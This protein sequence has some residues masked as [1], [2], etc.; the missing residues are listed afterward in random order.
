M[1]KCA[2]HRRRI[3]VTFCDKCGDAMCETCV[4]TTHYLQDLRGTLCIPCYIKNYKTMI[5]EIKSSQKKF[6][7][8][9]FFGLLF[10]G[11]GLAL[12]FTESYKNL[13]AVKIVAH[14]FMALY[15]WLFL[16]LTGPKRNMK[17]EEFP[18]YF[19]DMGFEK[20]KRR[21]LFL[22]ILYSIL[23]F[24][25][26]IVYSP[27]NFVIRLFLKVKRKAQQEDVPSSKD[28]IKTFKRQIRYAKK[29]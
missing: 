16:W 22:E 10:Y 1:R 11:F 27:I 15:G 13:I 7:K 21:S 12:L 6:C 26:G 20:P 19:K 18:Q 23:I 24:I 4:S 28:T 8:M 17:D 3:G 25:I 2:R 5:R 9:T 29:V 14:A